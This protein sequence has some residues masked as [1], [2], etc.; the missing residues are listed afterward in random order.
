[1]SDYGYR[2]I[3]AASIPVAVGNP[4][5]NAKQA[6]AAVER[7]RVAGVQALVLPALC[8][9]GATCGDLFRQSPLLNACEAALLWLLEKTAGSSMLIALGLPVR[10]RGL[11]FN[12]AAVLQSG[13]LLGLVPKRALSNEET[14]WFA[15][16]RGE[17]ERITFLRQETSFGNALFSCAEA[18]FGIAFDDEISLDAEIV[19]QLG[20]EPALAGWHAK[21]RD[22]LALRSVCAGVAC[23]NAG[24][25]ESTTDAVFS[26]ACMIAE[27]G[28]LLAEGPLFEQ[29][30]A[31]AYAC[32]DIE[33]LRA[34]RLGR[35]DA[36]ENGLPPIPC[37]SLPALDEA[38]I[39]REFSPRPFIPESPD[40][41]AERCRE[42]LEIQAAG[43]IKRMRH[44]GMRKLILGIS[45]GLD[46]TLALLVALRACKGLG[47][48]AR[49]V[50]GVTIP[51][52]GTSFYTR[53]T[54]DDLVKALGFTLR[55]IDIR[56]ACE[57]HMRDIGHD[58]AVQ[59]VVY[60]NVQA[61]ERTQLLMDLANQEGALL[62]GTGDLSELAL[63]WCT[64]NGD[65]MSMYGVNAGTPKTLVRYIVA[66]EMAE[67]GG[68][69][70]A[71]LRR[72]L[73]TPVSPELLPADEG[74]RIAQKTEDQIGSYEVHDFYLYH[75]C[76]FGF[77]P[78][79]LH[80]MAVRAFRGVHSPARLKEWLVLFLRRFFAQQFKRSCLPDGPRVGSV[81]LSPRDGWRMPSDAAANVWI[82]MAED[83]RVES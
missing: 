37:E 83:V 22:K 75:F 54:V 55:E 4:A 25:G 66:H 56:P 74:G 6:L 73:E 78:A 42:V 58:P 82:A 16:Y 80:F 46:S 33:L 59:D 15:A 47:L 62:L 19:L 63:G 36:Q 24:P 1:M 3:G 53:Q 7:A 61:R 20:A 30:G 10:G 72:V 18:I 70:K 32:I 50:L 35:L 65:H 52:F 51:G 40:R 14:R 8:L 12:C 79:K 13:K 45:G 28:K 23:A 41:L 43:L 17:P 76:R 5:E 39:N 68:E 26:G 81:S 31:A 29:E 11:L 49:R 69:V 71:A 77:P 21:R 2:N 57:L 9:S 38:K 27:N 44:T 64:Y 67:S 48:D 34:E 60:E